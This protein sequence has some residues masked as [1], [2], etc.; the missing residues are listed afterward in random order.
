VGEAMA[1]WI[2]SGRR[3]TILE[4]FSADRF[5]GRSREALLSSAREK[6]AATEYG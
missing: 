4:P 3:P 5:A 1:E 6:Y 2:V